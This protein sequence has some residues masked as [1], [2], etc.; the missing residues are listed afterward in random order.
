MCFL[1]ANN[2]SFS[3]KN[4]MMREIHAHTQPACECS[5]Q[6]Q[7]HPHTLT[8]HTH[9]LACTHWTYAR[10]LKRKLG[11]FHSAQSANAVATGF[12][13]S[14]IQSAPFLCTY[15]TGFFYRMY[16]GLKYTHAML[17]CAVTLALT[18]QLNPFFMLS[19][20]PM[21]ELKCAEFRMWA[22]NSFMNINFV[23]N[24]FQCAGAHNVII[25]A[26]ICHGS[27]LLRKKQRKFEDSS[28]TSEFL[29]VNHFVYLTCKMTTELV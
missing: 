18:L 7:I 29:M 16:A 21:R 19:I 9:A 24:R 28:W 17:C 6:S 27:R 14:F 1:H 15:L 20:I 8:T 4:K 26:Y 3:Q 22:H 13:L 23:G 12:S 5:F 2:R 10:L 11:P 25:D